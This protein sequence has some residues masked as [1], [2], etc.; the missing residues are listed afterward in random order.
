MLPQIATADFDEE[1]NTAENIMPSRDFIFTETQILDGRVEDIK[2]LEQA[3]FIIL[4]T[5]RYACDIFDDDFGVELEQYQ[6]ADIDYVKATI[7]K[8][9]EDALLTDDRIES[10]DIDNFNSSGN[11]V[12]LDLIVHSVWDE[13]VNAEVRVNV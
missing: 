13:D 5:E 2:E 4:S 3:I 11:D 8:T 10:I 7:K 12:S 9:L 6:G 1:L